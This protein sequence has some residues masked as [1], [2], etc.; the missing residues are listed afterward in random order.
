M[1]IVSGSQ[2]RVASPVP[3]HSSGSAELSNALMPG[4]WVRPHA[5]CS[6]PALLPL[7]PLHRALLLTELQATPS[8][9]THTLSAGLVRITTP[10]K[11]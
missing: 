3:W 9:R 10:S 8:R 2:M 5:G 4:Q 7:G 11:R 1:S 6:G